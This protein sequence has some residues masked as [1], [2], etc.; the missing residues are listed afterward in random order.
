[1]DGDDDSWSKISIKRLPDG[2]PATA[3]QNRDRSR[4]GMIS[5][6]DN[7]L[8]GGLFDVKKQ[9]SW[10]SRMDPRSFCA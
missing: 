7:N 5:T 8:A 1:V 6:R 3:Q 9:S 2:C 4:E 10:Q